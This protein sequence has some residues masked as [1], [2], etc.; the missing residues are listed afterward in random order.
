MKKFFVLIGLILI[1][2]GCSFKTV[3][4][5]A[6]LAAPK[7]KPEE[8]LSDKQILVYD[9]TIS[10]SGDLSPIKH[11]EFSPIDSDEVSIALAHKGYI[12]NRESTHF[13][14]YDIKN[15]ELKKD[16]KFDVNNVC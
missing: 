16:I 13:A 5:V 10:L 11:L 6:Q 4:S 14:I 2:T 8:V 1:F 7:V 12:N 15:E 3:T 9:R